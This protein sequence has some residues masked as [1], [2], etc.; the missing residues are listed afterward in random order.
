[1]MMKM[2]LHFDIGLDYV[3]FQFWK[4]TTTLEMTYTCFALVL[5]GVALEGVLYLR[6]VV[7]SKQTQS[8]IADEAK[9]TK[10]L[11]NRRHLLQTALHALQYVLSYY[12]M[13]VAMTYQVYFIISVI[14][15]LC[16]G[17]WVLTPLSVRQQRMQS[18]ANFADVGH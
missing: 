5:M 16:L 4:P 18:S 15:G 9:Y 8:C 17:Y 2:Y 11:L 10:Y 3:L 1:M 12:L 13:L 14:L 6:T 7:R